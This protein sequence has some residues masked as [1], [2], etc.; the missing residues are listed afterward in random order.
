MGHR[1]HRA[2]PAAGA[3]Q[4]V[5]TV[6]LVVVVS[7]VVLLAVVALIAVTGIH[8]RQRTSACKAELMKLQTAV[9]AYRALPGALNPTA[10]PPANVV[11]LR[12][13]GL[14]NGKVGIYVVYSRV[15]SAGHWAARYANGPR[16][17]CAPG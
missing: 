2:P 5:T 3:M 17:N 4:G 8:D 9:E 6:E 10:S 13:A 7:V 12:D 11:T 14:L 1:P 16:G 15:R